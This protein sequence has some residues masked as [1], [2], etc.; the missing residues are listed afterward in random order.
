M[1]SPHD[2]RSP[3]PGSGRSPVVDPDVDLHDPAQRAETRTREFDLLAVIA[4]G[5]AIGAE[6]R[7]FI[8]RAWPYTPR[9][10]PWSTMLINS[11]GSFLI[12]VLMVFVLESS[13]P[14]RYVRPFLGVGVLG[15]F[16]TYSTFATDVQRELRSGHAGIA[17]AYVA[18]SFLVCT[19][20]TTVAMALTRWAAG[21]TS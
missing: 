6:G 15:G 3:V 18:A 5:G 17:V 4:A 16:T 19:L 1:T 8:G 11:V 2:D 13:T 7:Y 14:H 10:F 12:G 9:D 20:A 21:R